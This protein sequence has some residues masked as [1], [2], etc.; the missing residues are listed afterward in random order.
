MLN[1]LQNTKQPSGIAVMDGGTV[2][3][4]R[5]VSQKQLGPRFTSVS[6]SVNVDKETQSLNTSEPSSCKLGHIGKLSRLLHPKNADG[7]IVVKLVVL[8]IVTELKAAQFAKLFVSIN[9]TGPCI[10][11]LDKLEQPIKLDGISVICEGIVIVPSPELLKQLAPIFVK[12]SGSIKL[13]K[14]V[15]ESNALSCIYIKLE[16]VGREVRDVH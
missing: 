7:L 15:Q 4:P 11:T 2:T 8:L 12:L 3:V 5:P 16:N 14:D 10:V 9:V 1:C 13:V 6:G